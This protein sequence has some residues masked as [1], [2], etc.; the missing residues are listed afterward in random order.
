MK[1]YEPVTSLPVEVDGGTFD[2]LRYDPEAARA[3]LSKAGFPGGRDPERKTTGRD[4]DF[5]GPAPRS[6]IVQQQWRTNLNID[7]K[8][9]AARV[10]RL[11]SDAAGRQLP[12]SGKRPLDGQVS[13]SGRV[14]RHL[15]KRVRAKRYRVERPE[16]DALLASANAAPSR[17]LRMQRLADMRAA[18][19]AAMPLIPIH[20]AVYSSL[21]KPYVRGWAWNALNE[22]HFKYVWHRSELE[23]HHM[24]S[25]DRR[26]FLGLGSATL[27]WVWKCE[28]VFRE[29]TA[30]LRGSN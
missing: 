17:A 2:V 7:V 19:L 20:F 1:G 18:L 15:R 24:K 30:A 6:Q 14:P 22:H 11:A 13:G 12:G 9:E 28:P 25:L 3:L 29:H 21:V 16:Y 8:L 4:A 10:G 23:G 26:A 5:R 27:R